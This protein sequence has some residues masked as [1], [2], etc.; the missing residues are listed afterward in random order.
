MLTRTDLY[1]SLK[2]L[3]HEKQEEKHETKDEFNVSTIAVFLLIVWAEGEN[4][5]GGDDCEKKFSFLP[6]AVSL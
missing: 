1:Y 5:S 4:R 6:I 3:Q 2:F